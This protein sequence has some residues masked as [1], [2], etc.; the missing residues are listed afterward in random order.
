MFL[1]VSPRVVARAIVTA[2]TL[3]MA[4]AFLACAEVER[5]VTDRTAVVEGRREMR[6]VT[7]ESDRYA[8]Y[9]THEPGDECWEAAAVGQALPGTCLTAR[10]L[11]AE[12]DLYRNAPWVAAVGTLIA[13]G[14]IGSFAWW[15]VAWQPGVERT[16][17]GQPTPRHF[18][19]V[20]AVSLMQNTED[21]RAARV[22]AERYRRDPRR[23]FLTGA[24][25]PLPVLAILV[26]LIGYGSALGWGIRTGVVLFLLVGPP[27]ALILLNFIQPGNVAAAVSRLTFLGGVTVMLFFGGSVALALRAPLA[28]LNGVAWPF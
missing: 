5:T 7:W 4:P 10:D 27:G 20:S 22:F 1:A 15:R 17:S 23:P 3:L 24:L 13:L 2:L 9:S 6:T 21:E 16:T 11:R 14:L 19:E 26:L 12:T 8:R 25:V 28:N 18:D